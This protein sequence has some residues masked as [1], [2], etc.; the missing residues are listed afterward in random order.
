MFGELQHVL[1]LFISHLIGNPNSTSISLSVDTIGPYVITERVKQISFERVVMEI[2]HDIG[3]D[4]KDMF[5]HQSRYKLHT[6]SCQ[7]LV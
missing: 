3:H 2:Y 5:Q 1:Q 6:L 4:N 7:C